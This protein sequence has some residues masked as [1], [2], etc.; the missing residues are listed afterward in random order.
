MEQD[1][2]DSN[3]GSIL[4]FYCRGCG[5][6]IDPRMV[7]ETPDGMVHTYQARRGLE[8]ITVTCGPVTEA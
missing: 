6:Y 8:T 3:T 1:P 7:S 5:H 4:R 2:A